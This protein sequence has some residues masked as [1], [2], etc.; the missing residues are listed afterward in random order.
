MTHRQAMQEA[1][2]RYFTFQ[3]RDNIDITKAW[4]GLGTEADYR[5]QIKD[6]L[7]TFWDGIT[8]TKRCMGWLILTEK[9][10]IEFM[11]VLHEQYIHI[12]RKET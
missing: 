1:V 5:K 10:R 11:K 12:K 7:M 3:L 2:R 6:G 4:I 8:P 9:G